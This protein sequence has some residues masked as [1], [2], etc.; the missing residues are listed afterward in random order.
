[1][2]IRAIFTVG[3]AL[4]VTGTIVTGAGPH[5]GDEDAD[6]LPFLVREVTRVHSLVAIGLLALVGMCWWQLRA[7]SDSEPVRRHA[8]C[9]GGLLV[10][11]GTVGYIQYFTGVPVLLVGVHILLAS[12][13]WI[14]IVR[15]HLATDADPAS[16]P[17]PTERELA[18]T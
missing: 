4:L 3:A 18:V 11:Q 9:T 7:R 6:R 14:E 2:T 10:I 15:L 5:S 12:L 13:T 1:M 17:V 8:A 16:V